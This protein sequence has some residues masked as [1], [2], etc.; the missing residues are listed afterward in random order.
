MPMIEEREEEEVENSKS[1]SGTKIRFDPSLSDTGRA[2]AKLLRNKEF[3][4]NVDRMMKQAQNQEKK[5]QV[6]PGT[7]V[8]LYGDKRDSH[9]PLGIKGVVV[10]YNTTA[11]GIVVMTDYGIVCHSTGEMLYVPYD[12]YVVMVDSTILSDQLEKCQQSILNKTFVP[13][14]QL[15]YSQPK[16]QALVRGRKVITTKTRCRCKG[17]KCNSNCGCHKR[18]AMCGSGCSCCGRCEQT[19]KKESNIGSAAVREQAEKESRNLVHKTLQIQFVQ[20]RNLN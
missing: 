17:G 15:Q 8:K 1:A 10:H 18:R 3:Q 20:L 14:T 7:I 16:L 2:E 6:R 12:Q 13:E 11:G 19:L 9:N 4:K 5:N